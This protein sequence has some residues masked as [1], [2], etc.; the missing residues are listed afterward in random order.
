MTSS[1]L[2][3]R[4]NHLTYQNQEDVKMSRRQHSMKNDTAAEGK[5]P[6]LT[7]LSC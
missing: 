2:T 5:A 7:A 3:G 4:T 1:I 6:N